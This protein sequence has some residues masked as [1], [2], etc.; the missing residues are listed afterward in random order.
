MVDVKLIYLYYVCIHCIS[1]ISL[2]FFYLYQPPKLVKQI[3]VTFE[4]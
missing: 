2:Y 3:W 4:L 1:D